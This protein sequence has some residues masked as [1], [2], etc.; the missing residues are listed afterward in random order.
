MLV[1]EILSLIPS[2]TKIRV[3]NSFREINLKVRAALTSTNLRLAMEW[4]ANGIRYNCRCPISV[5]EIGYPKLVNRI[6]IE[7]KYKLVALLSL[8]IPNL[9]SLSNSSDVI[10]VSLDKNPLR[11][12]VKNLLQEK[13][14]DPGSSSGEVLDKYI[15]F[16]RR[17][18]SL[19]KLLY[20]TVDKYQSEFDLVKKIMAVDEDIL[21]IFRYKV[22]QDSYNN[23]GDFMNYSESYNAD[24]TL[25]WGI[26]GL[27]AC[28]S[29][30][31]VEGL[32]IVVLIHE[33]AHAYTHLGFDRDGVRWHGNGFGSSDHKLKEGLAQYYTVIVIQYLPETQRVE[34]K[35]AYDTLLPKQPAAYQA[36]LSWLEEATPEAVGS[37]LA[38]M[39]R[40]GVVS[41]DD[42]NKEVMCTVKRF[43]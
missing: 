35:K 32:T 6:V 8:Y 10:S 12:L 31:S 30:V 20:D 4:E 17:C 16:L 40:K 13:K 21:G 36:H 3:E 14:F 25:Y 1:T 19:S 39:R 28:A 43:K 5:D 7:D 41:Y 26:I 33:L 15:Q 22:G 9:I 34:A 18:N 38:I 23:S 11:S 29:G 27:V 37:A 2:D 42:F 24:I